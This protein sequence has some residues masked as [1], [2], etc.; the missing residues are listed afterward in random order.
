MRHGNTC[1]YSPFRRIGRPR[2]STNAKSSSSSGS[3][4]SRAKAE[5]ADSVITPPA[6]DV[7]GG[8]VNENHIPSMFA[9]PV[10]APPSSPASTENGVGPWY[11]WSSDG[12]SMFGGLPLNIETPVS[13]IDGTEP[14][15]STTEYLD[16]DSFF[17]NSH[18]GMLMNG[19]MSAMDESLDLGRSM[20]PTP[21]SSTTDMM[22]FGEMLSDDH[23][24]DQHHRTLTNSTN[25]SSGLGISTYNDFPNLDA[26]HHS[27][28]HFSSSTALRQPPQLITNMNSTNHVFGPSPEL[29]PPLSTKSPSPEPCTKRCSSSLIQ[30]LAS[31]NEHLSDTKTSTLDVILQVERD[32]CSF[33]RKILSC[34]TCNEDKSSYML[35]SMV[36][37]QVMRLLE[38]IPDQNT[39]KSFTLNFGSFEFDEETKAAFMKKY[40]S[41]RFS[42]FA[43]MVEDFAQSAKGCNSGATRETVRDVF[44][45]LSVLRRNVENGR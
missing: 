21:P 24:N 19:G 25:G 43:N 3:G 23:F 18:H 27:H 42:N 12:N 31:L 41:Q 2:K 7:P 5:P 17:D 8:E 39:P 36:V 32:T 1:V 4:K 15:S 14:F 35:F 10:P 11:P 26:S 34:S 40:L 30:K 6:E 44:R 45:R 37:E 28:S 29:T 38:T 9:D 33:C 20:Q 13:M 22:D 16:M